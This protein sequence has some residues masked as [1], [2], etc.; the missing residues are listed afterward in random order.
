[1]LSISSLKTC[2]VFGRKHKC[3]GWVASFC[4]G[5]NG[6]LGS[7]CSI[8]FCPFWMSAF[9]AFLFSVIDF[10][11]E[12][13]FLAQVFLRFRQPVC[14]RFLILVSIDLQD[15]RKIRYLV[16]LSFV[17]TTLWHRGM[18]RHGHYT[19]KSIQL[20]EFS[21]QNCMKN[22][23]LCWLATVATSCYKL[24]QVA[25]CS[26]MFHC[27]PSSCRQWPSLQVTSVFT[28][29]ILTGP[30]W[31]WAPPMVLKLRYVLQTWLV[32]LKLV[33]GEI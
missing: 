24:L 4:W 5:S 1:M 21:S 23:T 10:L 28:A 20:R 14:N 33:H 26:I 9:P 25:T 22:K 3:F 31:D 29:S 2:L 7:A 17:P 32:A 13:F 27:R 16:M 11:C 12:L 18:T 19:S 6:R 8:S 30:T 15:R